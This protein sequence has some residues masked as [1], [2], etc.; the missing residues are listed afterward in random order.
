MNNIK[1]IT[2][3][4]GEFYPQPKPLAK[5]K[6]PKPMKK[7]GKKTVSW[8][9]ER[10]KLVQKFTEMGIKECELRTPDCWRN[11]ALGFAHAKK[12]RK[13]TLEDLPVVILA[14]NICHDLIEVMP[15][16]VMERVV[17]DTIAERKPRK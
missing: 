1:I 6:M 2:D 10:K 13:L 7:E 17:M 5:V 8:A 14:C 11:T 9:E 4:S 12:R 15:P 16:E 3:H